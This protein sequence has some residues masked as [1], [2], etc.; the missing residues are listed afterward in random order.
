MTLSAARTR[1]ETIRRVA[2]LEPDLPVIN[3]KPEW[4]NPLSRANADTSPC[5]FRSPA[6]FSPLPGG[7]SLTWIG[8]Y[9]YSKLRVLGKSVGVTDDSTGIFRPESFSLEGI[10]SSSEPEAIVGEYRTFK[11]LFCRLKLG[12]DFGRAGRTVL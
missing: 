8:Y 10:D 4:A 1:T 9:N 11:I 2:V 5:D 3:E 7:K 6:V 12:D